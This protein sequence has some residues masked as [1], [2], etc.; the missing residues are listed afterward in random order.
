MPGIALAVSSMVIMSEVQGLSRKACYHA[1]RSSCR[2]TP[3]VASATLTLDDILIFVTGADRITP[4][5]FARSQNY[6]SHLNLI[7][8]TL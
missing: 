2:F 6:I 4:M 5:G 8:S 7:K 1:C 3:T